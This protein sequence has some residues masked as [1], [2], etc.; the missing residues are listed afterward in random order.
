MRELSYPAFH[1]GIVFVFIVSAK[2][3]ASVNDEREPAG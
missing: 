1:S 3:S 2:T